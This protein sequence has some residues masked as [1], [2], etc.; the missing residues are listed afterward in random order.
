MISL[1]ALCH[2]LINLLLFGVVPLSSGMMSRWLEED[3]VGAN[4]TFVD[5]VISSNASV[6][7]SNNA[8]AFEEEEAGPN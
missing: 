1:I 2:L 7:T 4:M 8:S 5:P 3:M 6:V